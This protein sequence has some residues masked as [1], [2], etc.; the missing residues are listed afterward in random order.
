MDVV[1]LYPNIS[2]GECLAS[3][4][5]FLETRENKQ[6]SS[7]TLTELAEI[8][9]KNNIFEFDKKTFK[10]KNGTAIGPKFAPPYAI[11][12]TADLE[13]KMLEI[14]EKKTM[15]WWS[16]I[17]DIFFIWEHGKE[18]LRVFIDQVNLINPTIKFAAEYS[19]EEVNFL[20]LN[21]K[22][23]EGELKTDLFVNLTDTH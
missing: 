13:E 17:D 21:I 7:D 14:F 18:S 22:L 10:Q 11:L 4:Y 8:V 23:I 3:L 9:L 6:I 19:K 5:K 15:I 1:G 12:L 16:Y 20:D 2:H